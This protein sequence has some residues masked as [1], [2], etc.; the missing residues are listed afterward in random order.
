MTNEHTPPSAIGA[1]LLVL[2]GPSG[3][4]KSTIIRELQRMDPR[5]FYI[6]FFTTR[7]ARA[8]ETEKVHVSTAEMDA[9][10]T[11][12]RYVTLEIY[13]IRYAVAIEV[14]DQALR[15]GNYPV[16]DW[17]IDHIKKLT[18]L[19]PTFI[20]YLSPPSFRELRE[21]MGR[22]QRSRNVLRMEIAQAEL[23]KLAA[24]FYDSLYDT[25]IV[26]VT[27]GEAETARIVHERYGKNA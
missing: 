4:G 6:R 23:Q 10:E 7:E 8:S 14:I 16:I 20:V 27:Q 19:F 22:D 5:Y 18:D 13:D 15:S 1:R 26:S 9:M 25:H 21:R 12:G 24:G 11:S 3:V 2:T 17:P